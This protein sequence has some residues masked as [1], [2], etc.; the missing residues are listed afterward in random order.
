VQVA[1]GR[2]AVDEQVAAE[3]GLGDEQGLGGAEQPP[4]E[5]RGLDAPPLPRAP[6]AG[7][8]GGRDGGEP[9]DDVDGGHVRILVAQNTK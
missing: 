2:P 8:E 4:E 9:E 5:I 1:L 7:G 3:Q 6:E